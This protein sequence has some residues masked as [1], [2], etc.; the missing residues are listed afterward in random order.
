[1][2]LE[3]VELDNFDTRLLEDLLQLQKEIFGKLGLNEGTLPP[4]IRCGKVFI[5]KDGNTIIGSAELIKD[6]EDDKLAFLVGFCI[7][8]EERRKG[9]GKIFLEHILNRI[10]TQVSQIELTASP[11]NHAA[12]NLYKQARFKEVG[13]QKDAYG[14]GEDRLIMRLR[15]VE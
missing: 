9:K 4:M 13:F 14:A 10:G 15:L 2:S 8:E 6:W 3:I 5:L 11:Q 7:K 12:L 1:M